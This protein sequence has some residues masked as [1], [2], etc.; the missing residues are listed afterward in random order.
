M[1]VGTSVGQVKLFDADREL[2]GGRW[3]M[4]VKLRTKVPEKLKSLTRALDE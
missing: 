4:T 3:T 2:V 1:A